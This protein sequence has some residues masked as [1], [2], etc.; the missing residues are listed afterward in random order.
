MIDKEKLI[1][2][3]I[4][5][6][7]ETY[8]L[9][10]E[11]DLSNIKSNKIIGE[12]VLF[13]SSSLIGLYVAKLENLYLLFGVVGFGVFIF[14]SYFKK[15]TIKEIINS[16]DTQYVLKEGDDDFEFKISEAEY[17]SSTKKKDVTDKLNKLIDNGKLITIANNNLTDGDDPH[18]GIVKTLKIKYKHNGLIIVKEFQEN[19]PVGLP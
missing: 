9:V 10:T 16:G 8:F 13:I 12:I 18:H 19:E 2:T 7:T 14:F 15:P 5:R 11:N 1:R 6:R 17:G 4:K 3:R